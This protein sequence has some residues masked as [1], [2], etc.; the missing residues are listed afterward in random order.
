MSLWQ[1]RGHSLFDL[2]LSGQI[3]NTPSD[4]MTL[5]VS[6]QK[7]VRLQYLSAC[8]TQFKIVLLASALKGQQ[9]LEWGKTS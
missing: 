6:Q 7:E 2:A 5:I 3:V 1:W 8:I 9:Q 4:V